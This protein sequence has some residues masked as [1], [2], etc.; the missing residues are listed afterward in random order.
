VLDPLFVTS[1]RLGW[2]TLRWAIEGCLL[3]PDVGVQR[4]HTTHDLSGWTAHEMAS[5]SSNHQGWSFGGVLNW[6]YPPVVIHVYTIL[7]LK[8]MVTWGS[9]ILRNHH[10]SINNWDQTCGMKTIKQTKQLRTQAEKCGVEVSTG[11]K[12]NEWLS[13]QKCVIKP[14]KW[15]GYSLCDGVISHWHHGLSNSKQQDWNSP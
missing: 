1:S 8:A 15:V 5:K 14:P 2:A 4:H 7:V 9:S 12:G 11:K 10:L 13:H 3:H 6:G